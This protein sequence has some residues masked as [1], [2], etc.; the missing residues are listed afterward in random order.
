M[1][2]RAVNAFVN[3]FDHFLFYVWLHSGDFAQGSG[4][5]LGEHAPPLPVHSGSGA[6]RDVQEVSRRVSNARRTIRAIRQGDEPQ[7]GLSDR[8]VPDI[9][10]R[11]FQSRLRQGIPSHETEQRRHHFQVHSG[12]SPTSLTHKHVDLTPFPETD[13][14]DLRNDK[15][16]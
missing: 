14:L 12:T 7:G 9:E 4:A 1:N 11:A 8:Q 16:Y 13:S 15:Y 2:E 10:I 5:V 6:R 3:I